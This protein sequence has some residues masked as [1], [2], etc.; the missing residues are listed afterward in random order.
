MDKDNRPVLVV[1]FGTSASSAALV[2]GGGRV[3]LIKEPASGLYSW[4]SAVFRQGDR[5]LV[6]SAAAGRKR[7][8]P[9]AFRAEFKRDLGQSAP[10]LLGEH[11]YRAGELVAALL[12]AYGELAADIAGGP[13]ERL[14][15]SVP[16]AYGRRDPRAAEMIA[17]GESA[18]F[19]EVELV[20]EPVAAGLGPLTGPPFGDG[21]VVLVYDFGGGTFDAALV[22]YGREGHHTVLGHAAL[23]DC[24]GRDIDGLIAARVSAESGEDLG[25]TGDAALRARLHLADFA[26][27][28]KH[29]LS[30]SDEVEDYPSPTAAPVVLRTEDLAALAG[31]LLRRTLECCR[32]LIARA[33]EAPGAV[34]LV[35]GTTRMPL[36]AA[37]VA[38]EFRVPLRRAEDPELAVVL[39]AALL[40]GRSHERDITAGRPVPNRQPLSWDL[41]GAAATL[42]RWLVAEGAAFEARQLLGIARGDDGSLWRLRGPEDPGRIVAQQAR[43]G[44]AFAS[45]DWLLT[46]DLARER[47]RHVAEDPGSLAVSQEGRYRRRRGRETLATG[48]D[49]DDDFI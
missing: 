47:V 21:D 5:L 23:D 24:G 36:V 8:A 6:G 30:A 16:A 46:V 35:G 3:R 15:L 22:R 26:R 12:R 41:R 4:P 19:A 1:D 13:V 28:L 38:A 39:G 7:G 37:A 11:P 42:V 29:Q 34:L 44:T 10:V 14:V 27:G 9:A 18:G 49:V 45:G 40:A 25:L 17:A 48:V 20:V 43:P 32:G 31:P 33:G 2:D